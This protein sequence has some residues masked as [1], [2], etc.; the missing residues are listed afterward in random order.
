MAPKKTKEY[1]FDLREVVIKHFLNGDS[2]REIARKVL[3]PP[4][5]AHY[6]IK[7]YKLT[8]S[9]GK[10]IG[11]DRKRKTTA[12]IDR[13]IQHEIKAN[14]RKSSTSIKAE[15]QTEINITISESTIRR[16]T[17]KISLHGC[18]ARKKTPILTKSIVLNVLNTLEYIMKG[19]WTSRVT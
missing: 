13:I 9:I 5:C 1:S 14:R 4:S 16:R 3:I 8:K 10:F 11:R 7:K 12:Q 6:M 2:E 19:L 15:L 18:L 17:N